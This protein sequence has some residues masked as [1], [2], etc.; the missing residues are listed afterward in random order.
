MMACPVC[1]DNNPIYNVNLLRFTYSCGY[2]AAFHG[3]PELLCCNDVE[4]P[5]VAKTPDVC[6]CDL[7]VSGCTCGVFQREQAQKQ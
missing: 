6:T 5:Y 4:Q 2:S 7:M 3:D 1:G